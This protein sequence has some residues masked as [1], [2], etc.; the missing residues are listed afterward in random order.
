M[1]ERESEER[2]RERTNSTLESDR[3]KHCL[4]LASGVLDVLD[5][6]RAISVLKLKD[7]AGDL[8]QVRVELALVPLGKDVAKLV[9]SESEGLLEDVV[10]LAD[11]L[12]VAVFD[13]VVD[14]LD[15]VTSA[16][17]ADPVATGLAIDLGSNRLEDGL[18]MGPIL[19]I[20]F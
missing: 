8:D 6:S 18:Y 13:S 12:H 1:C 14:H 4:Y 16:S 5:Q 9:G 11:H 19:K 2:G 3:S 7:V 20:R 15:V 17:L 10:G